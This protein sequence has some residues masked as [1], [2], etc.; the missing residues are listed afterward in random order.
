MESRNT[1]LKDEGRGIYMK[2]K[3]VN[4]GKFFRRVILLF[5]VLF[6]I[7]TNIKN[8]T[9]SAQIQNY[10]TITVNSGDTLWKIAQYEQSENDYYKKQDIRDIV[11][12]IKEVNNLK[13]SSLTINQ[14]LKIPVTSLEK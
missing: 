14:N 3:I 11:L 8:S 5:I 9:S 1:F 13:S 12:N 7:I 6:F 2:Y 4:K 10:K